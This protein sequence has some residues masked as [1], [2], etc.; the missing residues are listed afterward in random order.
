MFVPKQEVPASADHGQAAMTG[1][2]DIELMR[3]RPAVP[4]AVTALETDEMHLLATV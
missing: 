4:T 1:N 2:L 3:V